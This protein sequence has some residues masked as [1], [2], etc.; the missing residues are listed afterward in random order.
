MLNTFI[1]RKKVLGIPHQP[2]L[3]PPTP[4]T[5]AAP[6]S[7]VLVFTTKLS[8]A[9]SRLSH[10]RSVQPTG[11]AAQAAL[12]YVWFLFLYVFFFRF[13]PK[14]GSFLLLNSKNIAIGLL[15]YPSVHEHSVM[16]EKVL[17]R[18]VHVFHVNISFPFSG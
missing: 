6:S 14:M 3:P 15:S 7:S 10:E 17:K 1:I 2:P 9:C 4:R 11:M 13:T 12:R 8:K 5:H 18:H 16:Q